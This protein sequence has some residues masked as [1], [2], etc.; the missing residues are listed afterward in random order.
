MK[1]PAENRGARTP[2]TSK[3]RLMR[4]LLDGCYYTLLLRGTLESFRVIRYFEWVTWEG[5]KA[6]KSR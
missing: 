3:R 4:A 1:T 6:G 5:F 2:A